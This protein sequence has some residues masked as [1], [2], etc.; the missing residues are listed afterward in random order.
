MSQL[1]KI[2]FERYGKLI[3]FNETRWKI[4]QMRVFIQFLPNL[5]WNLNEFSAN[6]CL[7]KKK[8]VVIPNEL[9][10]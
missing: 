3:R 6:F 7:D 2:G 5:K 4:E 1:L 9:V 10:R 8:T